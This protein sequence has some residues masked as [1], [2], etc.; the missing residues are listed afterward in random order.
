ML[1][2]LNLYIDSIQ[3]RS[4]WK[5]KKCHNEGELGLTKTGVVMF[6]KKKQ[7][8]WSELMLLF[9]LL[10]SLFQH[11]LIYFNSSM[12]NCS[13]TSNETLNESYSWRADFINPIIQVYND[14]NNTS[15]NVLY[16]LL[17]IV[18][19]FSTKMHREILCYKCW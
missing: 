11:T 17:T 6:L 9:L 16:H 15:Q 1:R 3:T 2:A 8:A 10:V 7:R 14:Y 5:I 12:Q 4:D 19:Y 13:T 18:R